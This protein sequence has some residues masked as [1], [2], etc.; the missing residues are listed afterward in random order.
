[1]RNWSDYNIIVRQVQG[2]CRT[3]GVCLGLVVPL[4]PEM[5]AERYNKPHAT[6]L[7]ALVP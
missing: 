3:A 2:G 7:R 1:V 5:K 4:C 6:E